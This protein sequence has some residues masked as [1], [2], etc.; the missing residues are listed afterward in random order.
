MTHGVFAEQVTNNTLERFDPVS[1]ARAM[2]GLTFTP[3]AAAEVV[4]D[5][6]AHLFD[7]YLRED[8]F[9]ATLFDRLY[10]TGQ[11]RV[12]TFSLEV[13]EADEDEFLL[14]DSP[15]SFWDQDLDRVGF[16]QGVGWASANYVFMPLG[17]KH[18]VALSATP[19]RRKVDGRMVEAINSIQVR[20]S[21]R[22]IYV[23]PTSG[24]DLIIAHHLAA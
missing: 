6:V 10:E 21:F 24:L 20:G 8:D 13:L 17:P 14:S 18:A 23:R 22:E 15:V 16:A 9:L 7:E 2:T 1:V 4:P 3:R 12:A 19:R 11:E 5:L